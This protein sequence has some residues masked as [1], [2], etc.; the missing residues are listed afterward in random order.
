MPINESGVQFAPSER[1]NES[2]LAVTFGR[3]AMIP[4]TPAV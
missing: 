3:S 4:Y 1:P 2:C